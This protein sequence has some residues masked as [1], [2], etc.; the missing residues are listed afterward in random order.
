MIFAISVIKTT[1]VAIIITSIFLL[2][3]PY[4]DQN[5][6]NIRTLRMQDYISAA[7]IQP[8]WKRKDTRW[9]CTSQIKS[10]LALK[11]WQGL[12]SGNRLI[13]HRDCRQWLEITQATFHI[14]RRG[15][16]LYNKSYASDILRPKNGYDVGYINLLSSSWFP[17][18]EPSKKHTGTW[19]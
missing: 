19:G 15:K 17:L 7:T 5:P 6:R 2:P 11:T 4:P 14:W 9:P 8:A 18:Y 10:S 16:S 13:V 3:L 12:A 1:F